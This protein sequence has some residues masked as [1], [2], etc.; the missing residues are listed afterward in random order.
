MLES[1]FL[2]KFIWLLL[3][4]KELKIKLGKNIFNINDLTTYANQVELKAA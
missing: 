3:R 4:T 1:I 2:D